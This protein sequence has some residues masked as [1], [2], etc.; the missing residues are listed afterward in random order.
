VQINFIKKFG[1]SCELFI[2]ALL[3][4]CFVQFNVYADVDSALPLVD[5]LKKAIISLDIEQATADEIKAVLKTKQ[6]SYLKRSNFQN[7]SED[8]TKLYE[9]SG[10]KLLWVSNP[11]A[12][13]K[14]LEV[15]GLISAASENGLNPEDYELSNLMRLQA[16]SKITAIDNYKELALYD[17]AI[18]VSLLRYLHDLHYGRIN[19]K[20]INFNLKLR[21]KKIIDIPRLINTAIN[22]LSIL[23]LDD[24]SQPQLKQ[25]QKL[26]QELAIYRVLA[27]EGL[28][29]HL[30]FIEKVNPNENLSMANALTHFLIGLGDL[31]KDSDASYKNATIYDDKLVAGVKKFQLR[32]G[33]EVDGVLGQRTVAE[34]NVPI[35]ERISQL[36]LAMERL[37]WLPELT[38]GASIIV[39]IPA[40]QLWAFDDVNEINANMPNM[41][42][43][44]GK[45]LKNETP[46]LMAEMRFIDF[47]PYWNV[48][49]NIVKKEIVPKLIKN[50]SYLLGEN[51]EMVATDQGETKIVPFSGATLVGLNQGTIRIRQRPGQKNALGKV[52]FMFPNKNDVYLHDTPSHALFSRARRDFSHGCVRVEKPDQLAEFVLKNQLSKEAINDAMQTQK[53]RRIMLKKSIP[54]LFFYTTA[55]VDHNNVLSFYADIYG[56]DEVLKAEL[57]KLQDVPDQV[58]FSPP[59]EIV[60]TEV[61]TSNTELSNLTTESDKQP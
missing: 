10:N 2:L 4:N 36:E 7:R 34:L 38:N 55:F 9:F 14:A 23:E 37:R 35:F 39:N 12:E 41:R 3:L 32:H 30:P 20:S 60:P 13:K 40:F 44:V 28:V 61:A 43:V 29:L 1:Y 22:K 5:K 45:A 6:N 24:L 15:I 16:K 25:Y 50:P 53:S 21:D 54:V 19:P 31:S 48:P 47:M 46:V 59:E 17:T 57:K 8:I 26:K 51:M 56:Y 27:A 52:K 33:I 18:S 58:L 11:D 42:V 49:Y